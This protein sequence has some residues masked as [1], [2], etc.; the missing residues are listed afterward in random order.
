M[1]FRPDTIV[2][3]STR[4]QRCRSQFISLIKTVQI[5]LAKTCSHLIV[6]RKVWP[7]NVIRMWTSW[8]YAST[9]TSLNTMTGWCPLTPSSETQIFFKCILSNESINL[10]REKLGLQCQNEWV[11]QFPSH[12]PTIITSESAKYSSAA[13]E[14][15]KNCVSLKQNYLFMF[16]DMVCWYQLDHCE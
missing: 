12:V 13:H 9:C 2:F 6:Q 4:L 5:S 16:A 3:G 7:C 11:H 1:A 14:I 10:K 15:S 8:W